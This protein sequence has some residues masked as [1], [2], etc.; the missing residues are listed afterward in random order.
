LILAALAYAG[1]CLY[2][3]W[4]RTKIYRQMRVEL[5]HL[6]D[7]IEGREF[8]VFDH[9]SGLKERYPGPDDSEDGVLG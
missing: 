6:I 4:G 5:C 8:G 9:A 2:G 3:W 7:R 1:Y